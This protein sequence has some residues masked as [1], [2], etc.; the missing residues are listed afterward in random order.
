MNEH[1]HRIGQGGKRYWGRSGAGIVFTDGEKVLLLRRA[2][3]AKDEGGKWGIPGGKTEAGETPIETARRECQEEAGQVSGHRFAHFGEQ[4][5]HHRF[6]VFLFAVSKPFD[7]T[8]SHEHDAS[9]W[10]PI[11]DLH[12]YNLH[13]EFRKGFPYYL[14]AINRYFHKESTFREFFWWNENESALRA[15]SFC[16]G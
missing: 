1:Y 10:I 4:D 6:T 16:R 13:E 2:G 5:G 11:D 15:D 3:D 14:K 7:V 8:L 9:L 12:H